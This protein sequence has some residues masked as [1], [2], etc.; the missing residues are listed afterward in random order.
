V[1]RHADDVKG[2]EAKA[3][4]STHR[5]K[6]CEVDPAPGERKPRIAGLAS[7]ELVALP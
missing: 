6:V 2:V 5:N 4:S 1:L 7:L 3:F